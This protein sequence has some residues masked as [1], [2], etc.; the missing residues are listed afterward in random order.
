MVRLGRLRG[1]LAWVGL[2]ADAQLPLRLL[3]QLDA[4]LLQQPQRRGQLV[5]LVVLPDLDDLRLAEAHSPRLAAA[6]HPGRPRGRRCRLGL[7]LGAGLGARL[8]LG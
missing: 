1:R 4:A 6:V 7:R 8:G 2:P 5:G 3:I